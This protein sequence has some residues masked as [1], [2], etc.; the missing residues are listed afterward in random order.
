MEVENTEVVV[1]SSA[2]EVENNIKEIE[3]VIKPEIKPTTLP[4][5]EAKNKIL[6]DLCG[7]CYVKASISKH[8]KLCLAKNAKSEAQVPDNSV[9]KEVSIA[10]VP[11]EVAEPPPPPPL[12]RQT[13]KSYSREEALHEVEP[14]EDEY[15]KAVKAPVPPKPLT[16][17]DKLRMMARQGLP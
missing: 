11:V 4:V 12:E 9:K 14:D 3:N 13:N 5:Y 7:K 6:C 10:V 8:R 17:V 16:R 2:E 15:E 1:E